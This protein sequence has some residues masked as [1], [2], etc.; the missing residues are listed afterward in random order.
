MK[1]AIFSDVH[2]NLEALEAV[3]E[4]I[5]PF[6]VEAIHCLGDVVGYGADPVACLR[7][8]QD[9]CS[10]IIQGNHENALWHMPERRHMNSMALEA[11]TWTCKQLTPELIEMIKTW[12]LIKKEAEFCLVHG[13]PDQPLFFYYLVHR[14]QME[15]AL[16][17]FSEKICFFGHTHT[18]KIIEALAI[19][20]IRVMKPETEHKALETEQII[21]T[22]DGN[23]RYLVNVGSVGQPRDNDPRARWV[24]FCDDPWEVMFRYVP[25]NIKGV[26]KKIHQAKLPDVLAERLQYGK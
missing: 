13:S 19:D 25:Y 16:R 20:S 8:I 17:A 15:R 14:T 22:L 26:Q 3:L 11:I 7:H 12:P 23:K 5:Q 4:D 21:F 10:S 24:M 2:G 6:L 9:N 18:P 1:I